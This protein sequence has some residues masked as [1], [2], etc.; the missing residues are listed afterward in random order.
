MPFTTSRQP[1]G[2]RACA[3]SKYANRRW[4]GHS[5]YTNPRWGTALP[6]GTINAL[7]FAFLLG[8]LAK[9]HDLPERTIERAIQATV[10]PDRIEIVYDFGF[11]PKTVSEIWQEAGYQ[12]AQ[13]EV[14]QARR[15]VEWQ[16][17]RIADHLAVY[18]Q[19]QR[20]KPEFL[21]CEVIYQHHLQFRCIFICRFALLVPVRLQIRDEGYRNWPGYYR[22]AI[23][24]KPSELVL[25]TDAAPLIVRA[26]RLPVQWLGPDQIHVPEITA[27]IG[28]TAREVATDHLGSETKPGGSTST[29]PLFEDRST[30]RGSTAQTSQA[31]PLP[32]GPSRDPRPSA[33]PSGTFPWYLFA[34]ALVLVT[35]WAILTAYFVWKPIRD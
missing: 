28:P 16:G 22:V 30:D 11:H 5:E 26:E 32:Q 4:S 19:Q 8:A 15:F 6:R 23:L 35:L 1:C 33:A 24:G 7:I 14:E 21:R 18:V 25:R 20:L 27:L 3:A 9:G 13:D 12:P 34:L 2:V 31:T 17:P 29:K 10:F